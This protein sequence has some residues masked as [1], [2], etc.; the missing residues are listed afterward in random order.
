MRF[1]GVQALRFV[2]AFLVLVTHA[3]FYASD[4]LDPSVGTWWFGAVGV[5]VFFVI[6]G[7][8]MMVSTPGL[9][10]DGDGA[11][12]FGYRRVIRIAPMYW[13]ATTVKILTVMAV[14]AVALHPDLSP[15]RVLASYFFL[16]TRGPTGE[17]GV[18][19]GVGWTL[20]FEM[21]FYLLFTLGLALRLDPMLFSGGALM[22]V[23]AGSFLRP[24]TGWP[25]WSYHFSFIVVYFVIGMALGRLVL[26][27]RLRPHT[28]RVAAGAVAATLV[29][30]LLPG[31]VAWENSSPLRVVAVT[32]FVTC[33]VAAEPLLRGR[34]PRPAL[35][36]GDASY[37]LYL[38]H[39]LVG[40]VVPVVLARA[41]LIDHTV[42]TVLTI[43]LAVAA[44]AFLF[45]FVE[46]PVTGR[47]RGLE[48][49]VARVVLRRRQP[50][51]A[52]VPAD[53]TARPD[54]AT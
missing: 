3:S 43:V 38:F 10:R 31:G 28:P 14:P 54:T 6:S 50:A 39:P 26:S 9:S 1:E 51:P 41:G 4:R 15:G 20:V 45:R 33:V 40:P 12:R 32:A 13:I 30:A 27:E 24:E 18:I 48:P 19:L 2:A 29:I 53:A 7:F 36:L 49:R 11:L 8:V 47:L 21:L 25:V 22:L 46:R 17:T 35:F 52:A 34:L 42:A 16:P 37:S 5:D 44:G 23:A